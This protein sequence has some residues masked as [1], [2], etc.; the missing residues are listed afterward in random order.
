MLDRQR[1]ESESCASLAMMIVTWA[2]MLIC[3]MGRWDLSGR[4]AWLGNERL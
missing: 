4:T 1:L 2:F 3:L